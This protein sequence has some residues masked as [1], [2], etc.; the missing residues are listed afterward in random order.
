MMENGKTATE[1]KEEVDRCVDC[2]TYYSGWCDKISGET[3]ETEPSRLVYTRNEPYG[4][5]GAISPWNYPLEMVCWKVIPCLAAGNVLVLKPSEETPLS[6][7]AFAHCA[8][9]CGIPAGVLNV[10]PG[11]GPIAGKALAENKKVKK[12]SFTG[13]TVV[14][15]LI[16][17][18]A[19]KSNMKD[20]SLECGGKSAVIIFPD[21]DFEDMEHVK[22]AVYEN[23]G[24]NCCQGSRLMVH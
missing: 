12:I 20:V 2:C 9:E 18:Y 1:A 6:A 13:S 11:L 14:G 16:S 15:R 22:S 3:I 21:F 7:L 10:V 5:C 19:A 23:M 8:K 24:Q 17:E 4:V